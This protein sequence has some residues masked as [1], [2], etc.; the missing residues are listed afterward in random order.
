MNFDVKILA[1]SLNPVGNRLTT[2]QLTYPRFIHSELLT[3]REFSRNSASSR[4]IPVK[5]MLRNISEFPVT[6]IHWGKNQKGMQADFEIDEIDEAIKIW[7]EA[8]D[9]AVKSATALMDL[10][11]HKQIANR[12]V[13]PFMWITVIMSTTNLA[14]FKHLRV[15]P[16]AEPH[17]QKLARMISDEYVKNEPKNLKHGDWH[18][19]LVGFDGD[20]ALPITE[21][22]KL[23]TARCARV[24]YLTHEG[25]RDVDKDID[26]HDRLLTNGH[27]SPFEHPAMALDEPVRS[28]NFVGFRQYRKFHEG[29]YVTD[30]R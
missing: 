15:S 11:V 28:G 18:L 20:D 5:K 30:A 26:L 17:F 16:N 19:P 8:R 1:D 27:W 12:L 2:F 29:E 25:L 9:N 13:E 6:P 14:H 21:R 22:V 4:A 24:S 10:G 7:L 23:S 3:H